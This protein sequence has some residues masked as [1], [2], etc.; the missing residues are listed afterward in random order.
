MKR[1]I[2]QIYEIQDPREAES[3]IDAGVDHVGSVLVKETEWRLPLLRETIRLV[4]NAGRCSS[5]IP[6][7]GTPETVFQLID[8]Y[9]PDIIHF[10]D[11]INP[12]SNSDPKA[13]QA[14]VARDCEPMLRLQE[15][16]KSRYP[17][18][19]IMRSVPIPPA[20]QAPCFPYLEIAAFFESASDYFL[21]DTILAADDASSG[22]QQPENGFVGITGATCDWDRAAR[23]IRETPTP[24][25]L[26]G[27]ISPENVRDGILRTSPAGVDSCTLTNQCD[28]SGKPMR[29]KKDFEK[30]AKL[31]R[32]AR[33]A[34][35]GL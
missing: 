20:G 6:L 15:A 22:S 35:A 8:Y 29:F 2:V 17:D 11:A 23:L 18:L 4:Q 30:V 27:G 14:A 9:A 32:A 5:L 3:A 10:C 31:V 12:G 24:V 26:A 13:V 16:V 1:I 34:V 25:I 19:K 7:F 21:T 28:G 33:R